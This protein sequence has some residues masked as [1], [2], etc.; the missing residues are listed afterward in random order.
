MGAVPFLSG[1]LDPLRPSGPGAVPARH[2]VA[3]H[4]A[5]SG[6]RHRGETWHS[7]E[8]SPGQTGGERNQERDGARSLPCCGSRGRQ[9]RAAAEMVATDAKTGESAR[10]WGKLERTFQCTREGGQWRILRYRPSHED[11]AEQLLAAGTG[12]V[13]DRL[14]TDNADLLTSSLVWVLCQ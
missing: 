13:R 2:G 5:Q 14:L 9:V 8:R 1:C 6:T 3:A 10:G 4:P 12:G 7:G 11:L